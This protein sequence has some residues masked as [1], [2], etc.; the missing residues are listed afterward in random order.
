MICHMHQGNLFVNPYLGYIWWDQETDG[1]FMYPKEQHDPTDEEQIQSLPQESRGRRRARTLGRPQFPRESLRVES[2][3]EGHA[4]RRLPRPRLG[5]PRHLQEGPP[6]RPARRR[7]QD[8][9]ARRSR[10]IRQ[11]RSPQGHPPRPRHAVRRLPLHRPTSTATACSTASRATP[12]PSRASIAT[13]PST[14]GPPS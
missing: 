2:E 11:G 14:S 1:E 4:V 6:W 12:R 5:L 9:S 8:H 13:A 10:Q 7:R 3:A